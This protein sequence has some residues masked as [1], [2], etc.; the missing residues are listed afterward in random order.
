MADGPPALPRLTEWPT[1]PVYLCAAF[2][3][4]TL[5]SAACRAPVQHAVVVSA[6]GCRIDEHL[7]HRPAETSSGPVTP[8]RPGVDPQARHPGVTLSDEESSGKTLTEPP[9]CTADRRVMAARTWPQTWVICAPGRSCPAPAHICRRP[10]CVPAVRP[11][12][13]GDRVTAISAGDHLLLMARGG[14]QFPYPG[15]C[16]P[17]IRPRTNAHG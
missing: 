17:V 10:P 15:L 11:R 8:N 9:L 1:I 2:V 4:R 7:G 14:R 13:G 5:A 3:P 6:A 16:R 12:S